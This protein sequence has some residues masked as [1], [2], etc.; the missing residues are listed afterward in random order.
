MKKM[1]QTG[2]IITM[3]FLSATT[4]GQTTRSE[5]KETNSDK[6]NAKT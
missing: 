4:F 5:T 3:I 6:K 1:V 2:F